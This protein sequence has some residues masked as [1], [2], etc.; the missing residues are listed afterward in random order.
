MNARHLAV[1]WPMDV[2][3]FL[4]RNIPFSLE[5][6]RGWEDMS[7]TAYQIGCEALVALGQADEAGYGAVPRK[8]PRLPDILP[9]W[10]DVCVA[11][12]KLAKQQ[13]L[14]IYRLPDGSIP[15]P[16]NRGGLIDYSVADAP[17]LPAPN[18]RS[19]WGLGPAHAAPDVQSVL[20]SLGLIADGSWTKAAETILWRHL[21]R[22]W[23]ID[24]PS[25][26]RFADAV[27]RAIDTVPEDIRTEMDRIVTITEADVIASV[28]SS[29]AFYEAQRVIFG[30]N[31]QRSSPAT[32]DQE[33]KSLE[34][35]RRGN[36]DWLFFCRWRLSDGWLTHADA[37]KALKIFHDP[38]AIAMRGAVIGRL[39]P[40]LR[41]LTA[42]P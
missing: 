38:L 33:R 18:I 37:R 34:F 8:N 7:M 5:G 12:L 35:A 28:A 20:Q 22:E 31:A 9:R 11:V 15:A 41:F 21:P 36:L 30:K 26:A 1:H 2:I 19:A 27:V 17:P 10:D 32:A 3:D 29:V 16:P 13:N 4:S 6:T 23:E 40:D 42:I 14:L 25:D 39:Y 24:V